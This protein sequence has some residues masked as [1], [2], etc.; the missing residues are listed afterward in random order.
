MKNPK[1]N[2]S[3]LLALTFVMW[4]LAG[5]LWTIFAVCATGMYLNETK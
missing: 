2:A 3:S 4:V 1:F 5:L